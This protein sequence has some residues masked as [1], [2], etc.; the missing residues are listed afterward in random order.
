MPKIRISFEDIRTEAKELLKE[1]K[2]SNPK[3]NLTQAQTVLANKYDCKS[4]GLLRNKTEKNNGFLEMELTNKLVS[5]S[6]DLIKLLFNVEPFD[7]NGISCATVSVIGNKDT[8]AKTVRLNGKTINNLLDDKITVLTFH[9]HFKNI[10]EDD[11]LEL[12]CDLLS[13]RNY[14]FLNDDDNSDLNK[15]MQNLAK[16]YGRDEGIF[17]LDFP[18]TSTEDY[19]NLDENTKEAI[20]SNIAF[21]TILKIKDNNKL[22]TG[23]TG[24]GKTFNPLNVNIEDIVNNAIDYAYKIGDKDECT[25]K[26]IA[27]TLSAIYVGNGYKN[28]YDYTTPNSDLEIDSIEMLER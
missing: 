22:Q 20:E 19:E 15:N 26:H 16:E 4:F 8:A 28:I 21:S 17:L 7:D 18:K 6:T 25:D 11:Y 5:E 13:K 24:K 27:H 1:L 14:I 9:E 10:Y 2:K 23:A 3:I 12:V